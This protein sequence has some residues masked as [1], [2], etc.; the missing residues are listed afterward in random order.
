MNKKQI[1]ERRAEIHDRMKAIRASLES[2]SEDGKVTFRD[3][4]DAERTEWDSI[5][6]EFDALGV[7]LRDIESMERV[8]REMDQN[9]EAFDRNNHD[10]GRRGE[11]TEETRLLAFQAWA[12][13][14]NGRAI[15]DAQRE[16]CER[17][18]LNPDSA[19]MSI[20]LGG[21]E[22]FRNAQRRFRGERVE[23]RTL[24]GTTGASGGFTIGQ[25]FVRNL[26][27]A[28]LAFGSVIR[29]ADVI[30][31]T[32]G[33]PMVWPTANDTSNKGVIIGENASI[34]SSVDPTFSQTT[35]YAYKYSS[36]PI[37]CPQELLEDSAFDLASQISAMLGERLGRISEQHFTTGNGAAQPM[38]I[39]SDSVLGK[40]TA[41]ATA[42]TVDEVIHLIH[43][44][45]PSYRPGAK[46]MLH[47][48]IA[49]YL[50]LLKDTNG[51]SLWLDSQA[52]VSATPVPVFNGYPVV[53]NQEMA[54]TSSNAPVSATKSI[55]FGQLSRYKV[56]QVRNVRFYRLE[57][58]YRDNDQTGFVAFLRQDGKTLNAGG[59]PIKHMLQA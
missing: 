37:L 29:E 48:S 39:T 13:R 38:G 16:A 24:S 3:M 20:D 47:D 7:K 1:L 18:G 28:M 50:R 33:E 32:T 40:T 31:T 54:S 58:R 44:V 46:L 43:S 51:R 23:E 35:W 56:R 59:N 55:L 49:M 25:T 8:D 5:N 26:E 14:N 36:K 10:A 15:T 11:I 45:D 19:E 30:R 27:T 6:N 41:S 4:S 9:R 17:T 52:A 57:E 34:G 2:K 53:I 12:R 21:S 42:I 22:S